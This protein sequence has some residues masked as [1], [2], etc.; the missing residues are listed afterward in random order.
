MFILVWWTVFSAQNIDT[1]VD[2]CQ[3]DEWEYANYTNTTA[4]DKEDLYRSC[5]A[6]MFVNKKLIFVLAGFIQSTTNV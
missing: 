5:I 6:V 1:T 4:A 3:Q 2:G